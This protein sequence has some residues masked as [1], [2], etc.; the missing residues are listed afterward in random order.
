MRIE[1]KRLYMK[2]RIA[3]T[4][5]ACIVSLLLM[6]CFQ[7]IDK[8]MLVGVW[9][10]VC[11][12]FIGFQNIIQNTARMSDDPLKNKR[13]LQVA[14][15]RRYLIYALIF[16]LGAYLGVNVLTMLLG[17]MCHKVSIVVCVVLDKE[18][19]RIHAAD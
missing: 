12:G 6:I 17:I 3:T 13:M 16:S 7:R 15:V 11:A 9:I 14:Y 2:I 10:G 1:D 8:A 18:R 19:R 4:V 5:F